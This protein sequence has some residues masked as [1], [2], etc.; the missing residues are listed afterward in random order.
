MVIRRGWMWR[1]QFSDKHDLNSGMFTIFNGYKWIAC[2]KCYW[3]YWRNLLLTIVRRVEFDEAQNILKHSSWKLFE[4]HV[5][6]WRKTWEGGHLE[7]IIFAWKHW[8][9]IDTNKFHILTSY[10]LPL[11]LLI[12]FSEFLIDIERSLPGCPMLE[13]CRNVTHLGIWYGHHS[14]F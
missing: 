3:H 6:V 1:G 2:T 9:A 5:E 12:P 13:L 14:G 4:E 8:A 11:L 10:R 7:V